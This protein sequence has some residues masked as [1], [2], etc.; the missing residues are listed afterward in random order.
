VDVILGDGP[1]GDVVVEI[2]PRLTTSYVGLRALAVDNLVA[3]MLRVAEGRPAGVNWRAGRAEWRI[4]PGGITVR[5]NRP[6]GG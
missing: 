4:G 6:A 1:A 2:N 5:L 3:A